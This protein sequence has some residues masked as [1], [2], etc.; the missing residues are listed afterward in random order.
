MAVGIILT[1]LTPPQLECGEVQGLAYQR[2]EGNLKTLR[3]TFLFT[4]CVGTKMNNM[5][6]FYFKKAHENQ[7]GTTNFFIE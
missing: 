1:K 3:A 7:C 6:K 4:F 2:M 5:Y